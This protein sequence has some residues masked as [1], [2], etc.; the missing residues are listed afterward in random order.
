[1]EAYGA[2]GTGELTRLHT[3]LHDFGRH[4]ND[5]RCDARDAAGEQ[6]CSIDPDDLGRFCLDGFVNAEEQR[7]RWADA[8]QISPDP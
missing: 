4:A 8:C 1:M 6:R 7:R 2:K 5:G 3:L